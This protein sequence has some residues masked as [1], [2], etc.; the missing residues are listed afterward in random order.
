[1]LI[2]GSIVKNILTDVRMKKGMQT[3]TNLIPTMIRCRLV[4]KPKLANGKMALVVV[5]NT[6][7]PAGQLVAPSLA[8]H[9]L[10][11]VG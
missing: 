5:V 1:M 2:L 4:I 9:R 11:V 8:L 7:Q 6:I 10:A 3:A